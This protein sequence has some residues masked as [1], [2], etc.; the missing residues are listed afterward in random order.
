M[1]TFLKKLAASAVACVAA[2]VVA[3]AGF[4][5]AVAV[6]HWWP[7]QLGLMAAIATGCFVS[8]GLCWLFGVP[9]HSWHDPT[10]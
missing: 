5:G 10:R 2:C 6:E 3:V 7:F 1:K 4:A 9:H 8:W